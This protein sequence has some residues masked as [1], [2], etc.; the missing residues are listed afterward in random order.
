MNTRQT[1]IIGA[2]VLAVLALLAAGCETGGYYTPQAV[3][4]T[5]IAQEPDGPAKA[6]AEAIALAE[7][8]TRS[9]IEVQAQ[10]AS[11]NATAMA[12]IA[13]ATAQAARAQAD[14][15]RIY[16]TQQAAAATSAAHDRAVQATANAQSTQV[17]FSMAATAQAQSI[18][19]TV[20]TQEIEATATAQAY[21]R[22]AT[23][24]A[25]YRADVATS[26]AG[27][28]AYFATSTRQAWEGKTTATAES[29]QAT[30]QVGQATMT[31]Q[32]EKREE[33]LGYGRD[34]GIPAV[35]LAVV[36]CVVALIVYGLRQYA[37]RPVV[38]ERSILGDAEPMA[39]P[40]QGGGYAFVDLDRQP[41]PVLRVLPS[42][43]VEAPLLR[44][45]GQEERTTAR[46]QLVDMTARPK[47]GPGHKG[48]QSPPL[49]VAPP[50]TPPAPGIKSLRVLRQLGQAE[51]AG[52]LPPP[53]IEALAADW[54]EEK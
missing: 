7:F 52:F 4:L 28:A 51:R 53:L 35:L 40:Q 29:W 48:G 34:Y 50:P 1:A 41:G 10:Q 21:E 18:E 5:R 20:R 38:Y 45:A 42:G 24:T 26:T 8:G 22:E 12:A 54:E 9:A 32:A 3:D 33:V 46:D 23:A 36:G 6:T 47:L 16:A 19:A 27:A 30:Q 39:V 44:S 25:Q 49:P 2:V 13:D 14:Q 37:Q 43:V 15:Q 17:A 11:A 31:R